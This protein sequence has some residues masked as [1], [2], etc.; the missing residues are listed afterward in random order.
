MSSSPQLHSHSQLDSQSQFS[1]G[2]CYQY[3]WGVEKDPGEAIRWYK[4]A[5]EQGYVKAQYILG[6]CYKD[7]EG[8]EQDPAEAAKWYS[9]AAEQGDA[10]AQFNLGRFYELTF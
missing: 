6:N 5:A 4:K 9:K 1:L 10:N 7:G 8:V 3:G 2:G